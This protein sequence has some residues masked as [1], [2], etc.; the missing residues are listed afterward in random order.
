[1]YVRLCCLPE[2]LQYF[3]TKDSSMLNY[4]V[5]NIII[6]YYYF[7]NYTNYII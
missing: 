6:H 1:M 3:Y 4:L 5:Y 2:G 7:L